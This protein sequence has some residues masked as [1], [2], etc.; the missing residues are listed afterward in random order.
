MASSAAS[1]S[2]S[3][4]SA[5]AS[6][7]LRAVAIASAVPASSP[8][9]GP[10]SSLSPEQQ[11]SAA[12]AATDR[13]SAGSSPSAGIPAASASTPEPTSSITGAPSPHRSSIE[14]SSTN[15]IE[16]K[17]DGCTRRIAADAIASLL[18]RTLV[19]SQPRA[20][21]RADLDQVG[22]GLG[23]HLRDPET[24]ADLDQ[25]A[26]RDDHVASS[27]AERGGS[28]QHGAGAVVD[29][30]RR[31]RAGQLAEQLLDVRV[32][33]A[34]LAG[35]EVQLEVRIAL[36]GA[37][38]S[39]ARGGRQRRAAEVGVDDHAGGVDHSTQRGA[40]ELGQQLSG[41]GHKLL[42]AAD[43]ALE[44]RGS[45]LVDRPPRRRHRERMRRV[46]RRRELVY[47]RQRPQ[48]SGRGAV[49]GTHA[50]SSFF[51]IGAR[52]LISSMISRA[53]AKAASR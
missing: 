20:V 22:P 6:G 14:T 19:V 15:P 12:P 34:A 5:R 24:A 25:L 10:P 8:A 39:L 33:A 18:Q 23:D 47:G 36:A 40:F 2:L 35:R 30:D 43:G 27:A 46:E 17:F 52:A 16:R 53:P 4:R 28:E 50:P 44:H 7:W 51:Q 49:P 26:S 13:L 32:A 3:I 11:T 21:G 38:D 41:A 31:L 1:D 37:G 9:W 29:D 48:L 42:A 45:P